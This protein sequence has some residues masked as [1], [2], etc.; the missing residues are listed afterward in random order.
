MVAP[1]Y[2]LKNLGYRTGIID[3]TAGEMGSR[4]TVA[5]RAKEAAAASRIL[6][7]DFRTNLHL[8]DGNIEGNLENKYKIIRLIRQMRPI[9]LLPRIWMIA[10]PITSTPASW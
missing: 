6:K 3:L 1:F 10:I 7:V 2:K 9:I 5:Q 4:G 8:P